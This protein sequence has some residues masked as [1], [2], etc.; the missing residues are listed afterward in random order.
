MLPLKLQKLVQVGLLA[1]AL[2]LGSLCVSGLFHELSSYRHSPAP[3]PLD[4]IS[5]GFLG[6]L[7]MEA[8]AAVIICAFG[9]PGSYCTTMK[10]LMW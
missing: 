6:C 3:T 8:M 1:L 7:S 10:V 2:Q 4:S 9:Y 5:A